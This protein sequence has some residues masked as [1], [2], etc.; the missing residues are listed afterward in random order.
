MAILLEAME[1]VTVDV[2]IESK[3]QDGPTEHSAQDSQNEYEV[4]ALSD[5]ELREQLCAYGICPGPVLPSTRTIY[6]KKL[7]RLMK[8]FPSVA[9]GKKKGVGDFEEDGEEAGTGEV[10]Y[11]TDDL[12]VT[13][14]CTPGLDKPPTDAIERKKKLLSPDVEYSLAK[15][16]AELQEILPEGKGA[17]HRF[18]GQ[19]RRIGASPER[20]SRQKVAENQS[21]DYGYPD[22]SV[23]E[24]P[25]TRRRAANL[26]PPSGQ[27]GPETKEKGVPETPNGGFLSRHAKIIVF[28]ICIF[29][30]FV[31]I[32]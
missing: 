24:G 15:I 21:E 12:K 18:Q 8:R 16:V 25:S 22:A 30:F 3:A 17:A 10:V 13:A 19:R 11:E 20:K 5:T 32:L 1:K 9:A 23:S 4:K 2:L 29:I 14:E 26:N 6:E 27:Q 7:L 31:F 28:A